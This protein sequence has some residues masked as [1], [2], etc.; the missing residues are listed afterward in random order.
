MIRA[1]PGN[2]FCF[3]TE[4]KSHVIIDDSFYEINSNDFI[5]SKPTTEEL[6]T[7]HFS[8]AV[9]RS[10]RFRAQEESD[11]LINNLLTVLGVFKVTD[12]ATQFHKISLI[13]PAD[14][15]PGR[16]ST[17]KVRI[18]RKDRKKIVSFFETYINPSNPKDP[19]G[20]RNGLLK[21]VKKD[22]L[23]FMDRAIEI[24]RFE[25]F[26]DNFLDSKND[27]LFA[28]W[29]T[30]LGVAMGRAKYFTVLKDSID[31]TYFISNTWI[32]NGYI[33]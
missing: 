22:V 1:S 29:S 12:K 5:I 10:T 3:R 11:F 4:K 9:T 18:Y 26:V 8:N 15:V 25:L 21:F 2:F 27:D 32:E 19:Y 23:S 28:I 30:N 6:L 14:L 17:P 7:K 24:G 31:T 13:S 33:F 16:P 20:D